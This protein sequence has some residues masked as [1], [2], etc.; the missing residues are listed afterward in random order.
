M[1][2]AAG[3]PGRCGRRV[4]GHGAR[5]RGRALERAQLQGRRRPSC[6]K[7]TAPSRFKGGN[8][9]RTRSLFA[10]RPAIPAGSRSTS[11]MTAL[12]ISRSRA[13]DVSAINVQGAATETIPIRIDDANGA[14][15]DSIPTTITGGNGND[16]L[17][18]GQLRRRRGERDVLRRQ[19]QRHRSTAARATTPPTWATAMTPSAGTTARVQT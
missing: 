15:T 3:L 4:R 1:A 8:R 13:A 10:S 12:P 14:F 6:G 19:R 9:R 2:P 16:S 18:G 5:R 17:Q 7:S 11:A